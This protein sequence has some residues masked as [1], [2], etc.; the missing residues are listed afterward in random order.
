MIL[1]DDSKEMY[2]A[3]QANNVVYDNEIRRTRRVQQ[4]Y[5][6]NMSTW[7]LARLFSTSRCRRAVRVKKP[8]DGCQRQLRRAN[9]GKTLMNWR[10]TFSGISYGCCCCGGWLLKSLNSFA[11]NSPTFVDFARE[12]S[13][14]CRLCLSRRAVTHAV[15]VLIGI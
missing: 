4:E 15:T 6:A 10:R 8:R 5:P 2:A 9:A 13:T 12:S 3:F 14:H 11:Q 7:R 1:T